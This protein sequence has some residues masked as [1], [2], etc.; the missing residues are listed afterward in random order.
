[1][2]K[3]TMLTAACAAALVMLSGCASGANGAPEP[4]P[5]HSSA[6]SMAT[7]SPEALALTASPTPD[8]EEQLVDATHKIPG[9]ESVSK[10]DAVKVGRYVC[11]ELD[12]GVDPADITAVA[13]TAATNNAD[14]IMISVLLLCPSHTDQAQQNVYDKRHDA[15]GQ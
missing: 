5:A 4:A 10:S 13:D 7:P 12:S 2:L 1:M 9:L 15:A 11:A 3:N 14:M 6:T 8:A